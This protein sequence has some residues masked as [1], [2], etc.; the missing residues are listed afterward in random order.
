MTEHPIT[1]HEVLRLLLEAD[2]YQGAYC[3]SHRSYASTPL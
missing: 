2:S 1:V 3:I